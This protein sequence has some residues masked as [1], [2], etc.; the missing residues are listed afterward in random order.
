MLNKTTN[1]L[2]GDQILYPQKFFKPG[3]AWIPAVDLRLASNCFFNQES[4][5]KNIV[6]AMLLLSHILTTSVISDRICFSDNFTNAQDDYVVE[7]HIINNLDTARIDDGHPF[8]SDEFTNLRSFR[9]RMGEKNIFAILQSAAEMID[10]DSLLFEQLYIFGDRRAESFLVDFI[11]SFHKVPIRCNPNP[12]YAKNLF[13]LFVE[14]NLSNKEIMGKQ[15]SEILLRTVKDLR[16]EVTHE[17]NTLKNLDI[18]D[19]NIPSIFSVILKESKTPEDLFVIAKQMRNEAKKFRKWCQELD[20]SNNPLDY[21]QGIEDA[22]SALKSLGKVI[23]SKREERLQVSLIPGFIKIQLPFV[24]SSKVEKKLKIL[25]MDRNI[26]KPVMF[27][28]NLYSAASRIKSLEGELI[29]VF[30]I[31]KDLANSIAEKIKMIEQGV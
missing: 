12:F 29:R 19:I 13:P 26:K 20:A 3:D 31:P 1:V 18:Y 8:F 9:K 21:L 14:N 27:L 23:K 22:K 10:A 28:H 17:Y 5:P 7:Q 11:V 15:A 6:H 4:P 30:V 25:E 16:N 2:K 24:I